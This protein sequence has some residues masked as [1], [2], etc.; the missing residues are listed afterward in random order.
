MNQDLKVLRQTNLYEPDHDN[1]L[2]QPICL[3]NFTRHPPHPCSYINP[4]II[5]PHTLY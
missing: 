5:I 4:L 3:H 2:I 1:R